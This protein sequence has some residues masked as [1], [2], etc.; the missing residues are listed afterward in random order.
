MK[1]GLEPK[2]KS[3]LSIDIKA[4]TIIKV[5]GITLLTLAFVQILGKIQPVIV[6]ILIA[7]IFAV[8]L[9]PV[10]VRINRFLKFLNIK[11][12]T[13]ATSIAFVLVIAILAGILS[14][15]L[16]PLVTQVAEFATDLPRVIEDDFL[17]QDNF[18][19][20]KIVEYNLSDQIVN[21][22]QRIADYFTEDLSNVADI[23]NSL[24]SFVANIIIV[25]FL[26]FMFLVNGPQLGQASKK[27]F[28]PQAYKRLSQL[29]QR[30]S[31]VITG[32]VDGQIT[33]AAISGLMSFLFMTLIGVPNALPLATTASF[34]T[35]IPLIGTIL[36]AI[37][38]VALTFI[39]DP[40]L[41]L[42][43]I[44]WFIVY[45]QVENVTIQP[46]IQGQN[47][48]LS[49]L[50]VFVIALIGAYLGSITGVL[51]SIPVAACLKIILVDYFERH[52]A[53]IMEFVL[54]QSR[55]DKTPSQS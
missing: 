50:Q 35:L 51:L 18:I 20:S 42:A 43:L 13:L 53:K 52:R 2:D 48:N 7:T 29:G 33:I 10:V 28:R 36:G 24:F 46:W 26:T 37:I 11:D 30:M 49:T 4:L 17:K 54:H 23:I 27:F 32:Y 40:N 1:S 55:H 3:R 14:L 21:F 44:I 34:F 25:L 31:Q 16:L 19:V 39:V 8:A 12:R 15:A 6:L 9:N 38:V 5:V 47:T 41:A 45:Q 22:S